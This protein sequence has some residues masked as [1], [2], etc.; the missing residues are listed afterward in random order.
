MGVAFRGPPRS[1]PLTA[2]GLGSEAVPGFMTEQIQK[3][4]AGL[5]GEPKDLSDQF[6]YRY[7]IAGDLSASAYFIKFRQSLSMRVSCYRNRTPVSRMTM[8]TRRKPAAR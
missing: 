5:N 6:D 8:L 2:N 3:F 1:R 7:R 4:V